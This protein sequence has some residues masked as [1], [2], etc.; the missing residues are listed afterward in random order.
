MQISPNVQVFS[1]YKIVTLNRNIVSSSFLYRLQTCSVTG[2]NLCTIAIFHFGKNEE[3]TPRSVPVRT[4]IYSYKSGPR[5]YSNFFS[6]IRNLSLSLNTNKITLCNI[7]SKLFTCDS[8]PPAVSS[9][10][11]KR[12]DCNV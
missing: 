12:N 7:C 10:V 11:R 1:T 6:I 4:F 9:R 5:Y 8:G 2:D 3:L